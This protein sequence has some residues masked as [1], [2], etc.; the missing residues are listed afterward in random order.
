[1][2]YKAKLQLNNNELEGN[3][4][5]LQTILDTINNLPPA[6]SGGID[7]SDATATASDIAYGETAYV[8]GEKV[9]GTIPVVGDNLDNFEDYISQNNYLTLLHNFCFMDGTVTEDVVV[10]KDTALSLAI[11]RD[12]LGDATAEDVAAG[13]TFTSTNG[14]KI[15]GT[16]VCSG[17]SGETQTYY[18]GNVEPSSSLGKDGDLYLMRGE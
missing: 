2:D 8:N 16:H 10:R 13:K 5:D 3:N 4:I 12:E 18:V 7:T 15:T 6:G 17:G 14:A 1:M 11:P 9:T